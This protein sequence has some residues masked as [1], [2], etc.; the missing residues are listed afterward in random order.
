MEVAGVGEAVA[1]RKSRSERNVQSRLCI[2]SEITINTIAAN[3]DAL[4]ERKVR[5]DYCDVT[6]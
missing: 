4:L 1:G 6:W 3:C 2:H 5:Q